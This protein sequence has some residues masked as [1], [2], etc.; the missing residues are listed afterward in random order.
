MCIYYRFASL[1][2][3]ISLSTYSNDCVSSLISSINTLIPE[4]A[5]SHERPILKIKAKKIIKNI[6]KSH[7]CINNQN[8][9]DSE[10]HDIQE[11]IRSELYSSFK[12]LRRT[13]A[14]LSLGAVM[15]SSALITTQLT[16]SLP[17]ELSFLAHFISQFTVLGVYV[18]ASPIWEPIQ[19][20]FRKSVFLLEKASKNKNS[21]SKVQHELENM[22]K[23]TNQEFSLNAQMSRNVLEAYVRTS[24]G[25]FIQAYNLLSVGT[26]QSFKQA[27]SEIS[28]ALHRLIVL[29]PE[30]DH[31]HPNIL[32]EMN[33][34]SGYFE[35]KESFLK[36]RF[37]DLVTD[38]LRD[39][40]TQLQILDIQ[41]LLQK[42]LNVT[43]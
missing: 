20:A 30:I 34:F 8:C 9:S 5:L 17:D 19:S 24:Q 42:K 14:Y 29:Y 16:K 23:R 37:I 4:N 11:Q 32:R 21:N 10:I 2:L 15:M 25:N 41:R 27:A 38:S 43:T 1:L 22:W 33:S 28:T 12:S 18:A 39:E 7:P 40:L 31:M 13:Q 36:V 3:L 35:G 6:K 26:N